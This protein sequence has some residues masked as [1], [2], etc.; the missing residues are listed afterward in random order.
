MWFLLAREFKV[1]KDSFALSI[2]C[3]AADGLCGAKIKIT[4]IHFKAIL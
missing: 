4:S 2:L 1:I 3:E